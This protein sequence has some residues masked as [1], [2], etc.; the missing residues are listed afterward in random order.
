MVQAGHARANQQLWYT[1]FVYVGALFVLSSLMVLFKN[2]ACKSRL[3]INC[4]S[5]TSVNSA[6]LA[7]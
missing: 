1:L 3:L 5:L 4:V 2:S 6:K 7:V